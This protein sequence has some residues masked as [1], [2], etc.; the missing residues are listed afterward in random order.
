M[1]GADAQVGVAISVLINLIHVVCKPAKFHFQCP[2]LIPIVAISVRQCDVSIHA[3]CHSLSR[4]ADKEHC[5][6]ITE[7]IELEE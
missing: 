5:L 3:V 7:Q 6:S 1:A 4:Q 2:T